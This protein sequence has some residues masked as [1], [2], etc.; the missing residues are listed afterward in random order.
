MFTLDELDQIILSLHVQAT[1]LQSASL[2]RPKELSGLD[3]ETIQHMISYSLSAFE[4][5]VAQRSTHPGRDAQRRGL[6]ALIRAQ[7]SS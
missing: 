4:K 6:G 1:Y 7:T 3:D 5:A 2:V